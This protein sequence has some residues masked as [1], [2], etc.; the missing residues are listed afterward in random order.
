MPGRV[1]PLVLLG[2]IVV[3]VLSFGISA[4]AA[5]GDGTVPA[6]VPEKTVFPGGGMPDGSSPGG[7]PDEG[8]VPAGD[9]KVSPGDDASAGVAPVEDTVPKNDAASDESVVQDKGDPTPTERQDV[10]EESASQ[11]TD[12]AQEEGTTPQS[13]ESDTTES[14]APEEAQTGEVAQEVG[15]EFQQKLDD[16]AKAKD[17][18]EHALLNEN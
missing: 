5:P 12:S 16:A 6:D 15:D 11:G 1:N 14:D 17:E 8:N 18:Y 10:P 2:I 3:A 4:G 7:A 13:T 9:D